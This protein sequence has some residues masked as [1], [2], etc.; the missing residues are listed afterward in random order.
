MCGD[1]RV[2]SVTEAKLDP[3]AGPARPITRTTEDYRREAEAEARLDGMKPE[4]EA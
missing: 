4:G 1:C 3:Y 2:V